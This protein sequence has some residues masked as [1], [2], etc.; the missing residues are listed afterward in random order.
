M[1]KY[2][3]IP[4][5]NPGLCFGCI[6]WEKNKGAYCGQY[7]KDNNISCIDN[8]KHEFI[9]IECIISLNTKIKIL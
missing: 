4:S 3:R 5:V 1:P 9:F 7:R 2:I 6:F 8:N